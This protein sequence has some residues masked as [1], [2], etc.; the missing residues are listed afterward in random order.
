MPPG[1]KKGMDEPAKAVPHSKVT[2]TEAMRATK[3]NFTENEVFFY[4]A[5]KNSAV[6]F[7]HEAIGNA[8]GKTKDATRM[9]LTR[10]LK[11]IGDFI[12]GQED[13]VQSDQ[14]EREKTPANQEG[15]KNDTQDDDTPVK[16]SEMQDI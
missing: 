15:L 8:L 14:P 16:I 9:Q 1:A 12:N 7:D 2:K 10:L 6:K 13:S 11:D 5:I 4:L 3:K